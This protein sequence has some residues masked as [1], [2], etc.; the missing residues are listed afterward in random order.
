MAHSATKTQTK[1]SQTSPRAV[2]PTEQGQNRH[3][4]M[5]LEACHSCCRSMWRAEPGHVGVIVGP[6]QPL[7]SAIQNE[8][9][10]IVLQQLLALPL[11]RPPPPTT[12]SSPWD[13]CSS[14]NNHI[15]HITSP[16]YF[17]VMSPSALCSTAGCTPS[18]SC[19]F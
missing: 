16:T 17:L 18:A 2:G 7:D 13:R 9:V 8:L 3:L 15:S 19:T 11:E 1:S 4:R 5:Q 10:H 14:N 12:L 6:A